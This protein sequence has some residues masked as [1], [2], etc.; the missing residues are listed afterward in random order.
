MVTVKVAL[1]HGGVQPGHHH[2][3]IGHLEQRPRFVRGEAHPVDTLVVLLERGGEVL[4]FRPV[5][6]HG[7]ALV[8]LFAQEVG[9]AGRSIDVV[10][11][12]HDGHVPPGQL[13]R[14]GRCG[15]EVR[16]LVELA[17]QVP[18]GQVAG[19]HHQVR[20]QLMVAGEGVQVVV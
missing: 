2:R 17:P 5:R 13:H 6:R 10:V 7:L 16:H 11:A 3:E 14:L 9:C 19:D 12:R 20:A 1:G 8:R 4:P 18:L 15:Q